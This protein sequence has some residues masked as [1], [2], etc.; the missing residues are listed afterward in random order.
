MPIFNKRHYEAVAR[1]ISAIPRLKDNLYIGQSLDVVID[2]LANMFAADSDRF[3][4]GK[5]EM[6]CNHGVR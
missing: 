5:F 4:R 6:A 2:R 3:D 1:E